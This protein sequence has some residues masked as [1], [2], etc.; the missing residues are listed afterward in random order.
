ML[1]VVEV[2]NK[3]FYVEKG[4]YKYQILNLFYY[5]LSANTT[6]WFDH[7]EGLGLEGLTVTIYE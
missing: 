1:L 5:P 3:N 4:Y 6:K 7:F 2:T